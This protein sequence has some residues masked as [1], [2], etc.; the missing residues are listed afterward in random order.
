MF[1]RRHSFSDGK[2][3]KEGV[4]VFNNNEHGFDFGN[5][6][7]STKEIGEPIIKTIRKE[8]FKT[9][10]YPSSG[11]LNPFCPFCLS[12]VRKDQ[13]FLYSFQYHF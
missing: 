11:A 5:E 10:P 4:F 3:Q 8:Q 12:Y 1:L 9:G 7:I 13:F 6:L 2:F